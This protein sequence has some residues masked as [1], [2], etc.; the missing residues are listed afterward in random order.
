MEDILARF[1]AGEATEQE[2]E[3]VRAWRNA[4]EEQAAE[5]LQAKMAWVATEPTVAANQQMLEAILDNTPE[6]KVVAWPS[7][8]KYAAAVVLLAMLGAIW[9]FNKPNEQPLPV[10]FNGEVNVLE[11]GTI[12]SLK[13]GSVLEVLAFDDNVRKVR[14][15]GKAFFEVEHDANRPFYVVTDDATVQV[16]GTSFQ[17]NSQKDFTEV[18]VETGKVSFAMNDPKKGNMSLN[19]LPGDMGHIGEGVEGIIKRKNRDKNFLAWKSGLITFERTKPADVEALLE[20]VYGLDVQMDVP[21][22]AC[23]LTA[24]FNQKSLEEVIQIIASTF[25][26]TF[27]ITEDKVVLSGKGC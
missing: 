10:V 5:F 14:L 24:Q 20:D 19:L 1:F 23:R 2:K 11:D 9:Y 13:K 27:D 25:N 7:Y 26:W 17:V 16:L 15:V 21:T 6:P 22:T 8:F 4:N 3:Q 18:C 12:V